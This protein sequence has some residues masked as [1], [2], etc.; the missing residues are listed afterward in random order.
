MARTFRTTLILGGKTATG[1]QV[2]DEVVASFAAGKRP[3][4]L[5]TINGYTYRSTV[6]VMGGVSMLPVSAEVRQHAG[7]AAGDEVDVSLTRDT[8]PRT[9]TVP[10][11]LA[12]AL[13]ADE[14]VRRAF[15]TL[16][17]STRRGHVQQLDSARTPETRQRRL[18]K[19]VG[20][21]RGEA[22]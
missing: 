14:T 5:V 9:A 19:I 13:A 18:D 4:V 7:I 15:D 1:I 10:P 3:A 20:T 22:T 17:Y 16:N 6:A 2:P 11:D 21:L 12:A 8:E